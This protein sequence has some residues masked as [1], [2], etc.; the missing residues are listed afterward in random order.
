LLGTIV[1]GSEELS[2]AMDRW[3][4]A[5]AAWT[6]PGSTVLMQRFTP[7]GGWQPVPL[8]TDTSGQPH[9]SADGEGNFHAVWVTNLSG[10]DTVM[11]A[12][13]PEGATGLTPPQPLEPAHSGT[14]K[15]PR[16]AT[17]GKA[18][19]VAVWFRDNG[20]GFSGNLVYAQRYE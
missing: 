18:G 6:S 12:R 5:L 15:R 16:V 17:N 19:A 11:A 13:Y 4:R 3:G 9:V 14:S 2:V 8:S 20:T 7:D 1:P 10:S